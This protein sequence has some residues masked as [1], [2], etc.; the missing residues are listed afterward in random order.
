MRYGVLKDPK[1]S[2][3]HKVS[4]FGESHIHGSIADIPSNKATGI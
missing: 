1:E 4:I 2:F 3:K